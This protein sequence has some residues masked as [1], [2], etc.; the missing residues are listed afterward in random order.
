MITRR[1]SAHQRII[2]LAI[3]HLAFVSLTVT[4][5]ASTQT[6]LKKKSK[7]P[8]TFEQIEEAITEKL[9]DKHIA[10]KI[11]VRGVA[12]KLDQK[13]WECLKERL[14]AGPQTI[15]ALE[16]VAKI[17]VSLQ[18][19]L[20]ICD[21][22]TILIADFQSLD[23]PVIKKPIS[24]IIFSQLKDAMN[25]YSDTVIKS[26]GQEITVD[27]GSEVA[28]SKAK[29]YGASIILWGTYSVSPKNVLV[30][31]YFEMVQGPREILID[32]KRMIN[33]PLAELDSFNLQIQLSEEM[34][35]LILLT[36]GLARYDA[37]DYGGAIERFTRAIE[38]SAM[39]KNMIDPSYIYI[40]RALAYSI[41]REFDR[42]IAD[43]TKAIELKPEEVIYYF[44]RAA[45]Y[46]ETGEFDRAIADAAK[47]I[48]LK[49]DQPTYIVRGAIYYRKGDWDRAIA[50]TTKAIEFEPEEANNYT[51]RAM[52]M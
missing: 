47:T 33:A 39:P 32:K 17:N 37:N 34:S 5:L 20:M 44:L 18:H 22:T 31:V 10:D 9:D 49:P 43:S 30:N 36:L 3:A 19:P 11:R 15:R 41:R 35:Y 26:L 29:A 45:A 21:K 4:A 46:V 25:R 14:H 40:Y 24:K 23:D 16:E 1:L 8:V 42:A 13:V 48:E 27:Q 2:I 28:R 7:P 12:F 52:A 50:D 38:Q 51:Y 6:Q